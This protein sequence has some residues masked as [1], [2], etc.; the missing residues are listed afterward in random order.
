MA[1]GFDALV[2]CPIGAIGTG[3]ATLP[4]AALSRYFLPSAANIG[5]TMFYVIRHGENVEVGKGTLGFS[6]LHFQ[7]SRGL[8]K[9][10]TGSLL[11]VTS[12]ATISVG[13][14]APEA[15][16][17]VN[18]Y[19]PDLDAV[20]VAEL[21][22]DAITADAA[23]VDDLTFGGVQM[24]TAAGTP[25]QALKLISGSAAAWG[26]VATETPQHVGGRLS[27]SPTSAEPN[28]NYVDQNLLYWVPAIDQFVRLYDPAA[29]AWK[30]V[31]LGG[32]LSFNRDSQNDL[33]GNPIA[34][35]E[36][37]DVYINYNSGSPTLELQK[38]TN[39]TTRATANTTQDG[40]LVRNAAA[41]SLW[42]GTVRGAGVG[43]DF[44]DSP[45]YRFVWNYYNQRM[46][47]AFRSVSSSHT[48]ASVTIREWN[49]SSSS[50]VYVCPGLPIVAHL[51]SMFTI[52]QATAGMEVQVGTMLNGVVSWGAL[53]TPAKAAGLSRISPTY[54][55]AL[56]EGENYIAA[57][58]ASVSGTGTYYDFNI[59]VSYLG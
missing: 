27:L 50:R 18:I 39:A 25:G 59:G 22:A 4:L 40:V 10:T 24:P 49:N 43:G 45:Q 12:S 37:Y 34:N 30:L 47:R 5:K 57:M 7:I 38:W 46:I 23:I 35:A 36:A 6:E 51:S 9:S 14:I 13:D 55:Y 11:N 26:D 52:S 3:S 56:D 28:G 54:V 58:Q 20:T 8:I 15:L 2:Y 44:Y 41:K 29:A 32:N 33:G 48:Y 53:G 19:D 16:E 17:I 31:D 21:V 1:F 42:V